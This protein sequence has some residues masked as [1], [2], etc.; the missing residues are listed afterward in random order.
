ME[1]KVGRY[2]FET[3]GLLVADAETGFELETQTLSL[4]ERSLFTG[5]EFPEWYVESIMV[6]E[7]AHQWFGN[8]VSPRTW[9][10][11]WLNEGH[12]TWYEALYAEE[13]ADQPMELRMMDAY[14]RVG[15][16]ARG[17]RP[18][19]RAEG[20]GA[21]GE[22]QPVPAG[23]LRR[24]RAGPLRAAPGDRA[25]RPSTVWSGRGC[26]STPT[27]P[28]RPPTSPGS[29]SEVSGRDLGRFFQGWLYGLKTPRMPGHPQ[30]RSDAPRTGTL[31][32]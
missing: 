23:R 31:G 27:R 15:Q 1:K 20:A 8:S 25:P 19:G 13:K 5:P 3:Y 22:D 28:R 21:G 9:S 6:H 12:A 17:G 32:R 16:L 30:W 14:R 11:L 26:V 10:D 7:L 24:Q 2:P 4:F 18:A 29:R